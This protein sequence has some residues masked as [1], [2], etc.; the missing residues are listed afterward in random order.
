MKSVGLVNRMLWWVSDPSAI[1]DTFGTSW[2]C[3]TGKS[4]IYFEP[5]CGMVL[6]WWVYWNNFVGHSENFA[7]LKASL[8]LQD[9]RWR[10]L[11]WQFPSHTLE[12]GTLSLLR[13]QSYCWQM[14]GI[15]DYYRKGIIEYAGFSGLSASIRQCSA[16]RRG[17][18]GERSRRK[19]RRRKWEAEQRGRRLI[20]TSKDLQTGN[21]DPKCT[22]EQLAHKRG[23]AGPFLLF[24]SHLRH[25]LTHLSG[26]ISSCTSEPW[27]FS[28]LIE[29]HKWKLFMCLEITQSWKC[30]QK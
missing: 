18:G 28:K 27:M 29:M 7:F 8:W 5:H 17:L 16:W 22:S 6:L 11:S 20:S 23:V 1:F 9:K 24:P 2:S 25:C 14:H 13:K 26:N 4:S 3:F 19:R 12:K 10:V 21:S 30:C 15:L